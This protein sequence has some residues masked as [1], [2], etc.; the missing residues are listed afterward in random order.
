MNVDVYLILFILLC[1][2]KVKYQNCLEISTSWN[3][4]KSVYFLQYFDDVVFVLGM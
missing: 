2:E 3:N 4:A 1:I